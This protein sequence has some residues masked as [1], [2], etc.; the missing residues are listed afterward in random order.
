MAMAYILINCEVGS[1]D[2]VVSEL[3]A[4]S[5][6]KTAHG[7]FGSFD[8][9]AKVED[10]YEERLNNVITRQIRK[11][12]KIHS[13]LTLYAVG[14]KDY[15]FDRS[16]NPQKDTNQKNFV[17][18]YVI[19]DCEDT[20]EHNVLRSL[21]KIPEVVEGCI[22][23]GFYEIICMVAASTYNDIEDVITKKIRKI[24]KV[25]STMTLNIIPENR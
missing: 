5:S 13:T 22:V 6:V 12:E 11:L 25:R 10:D 20:D 18:A 23:V 3:K 21:S 8:V 7:T 1:D 15:F 9:I 4:I 19:I 17:Q 14:G 2:F 24:K 16:T